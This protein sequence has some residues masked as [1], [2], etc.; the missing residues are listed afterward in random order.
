M[1][2]K[3]VLITFRADERFET[4]LIKASFKLDLSRSE[5]IRETILY[6]Y[7]VFKTKRLAELEDQN[8][9]YHV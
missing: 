1:S 3:D 6:G 2:K 9:R 5:F 4:W 7:E 8:S